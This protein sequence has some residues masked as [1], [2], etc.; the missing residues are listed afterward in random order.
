MIKICCFL[1]ALL[2]NFEALAADT[3]PRK[4]LTLNDKTISITSKSINFSAGTTSTNGLYN[5]LISVIFDHNSPND[6]RIK[7]PF[8]GHYYVY[9][10]FE[11]HNYALRATALIFEKKK[12]ISL[13]NINLQDETT[14][15][16]ST[17]LN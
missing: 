16:V 17:S 2:S 12:L 15:E 9:F 8:D 5:K 6:W 10:T 11:N 1:F 13:E 7:T 3:L 4:L 14:E